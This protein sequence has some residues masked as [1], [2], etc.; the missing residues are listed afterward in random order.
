MAEDIYGGEKWDEVP[1]LADAMEDAGCDSSDVLDGLRQPHHARGQ[2]VV[3]ALLRK[4]YATF[5]LKK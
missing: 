2:W 3:D 1:V 5:S 4:P